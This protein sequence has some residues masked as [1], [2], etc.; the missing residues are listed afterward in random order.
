MVLLYLNHISSSRVEWFTNIAQQAICSLSAHGLR[1]FN[2]KFAKS[3]VSGEG[4][5]L[6][7]YALEMMTQAEL[8]VPRG[9]RG[10]FATSRSR[11]SCRPGSGSA[12]AATR[13]GALLQVQQAV[14]SDLNEKVCLAAVRRRSIR[15]HSRKSYRDHVSENFHKKARFYQRLEFA[16]ATEGWPLKL[17]VRSSRFR[18]ALSLWAGPAILSAAAS[19]AIAID[20]RGLA[21]HTR[22]PARQHHYL[23]CRPSLIA[24]LSDPKRMTADAAAR[25]PLIT[26]LTGLLALFF[27]LP[28]RWWALARSQVHI[29]QGGRGPRRFFCSSLR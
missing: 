5:R 15:G 2:L 27:I 18:A 20:P 3:L 6:V 26:A 28:Q 8:A 21:R 16:V 4:D 11:Q 25:I 23:S 24:C 10:D 17:P 13:A 1:A 9:R 14:S 22:L 19:G 7:V 29:S 12:Q